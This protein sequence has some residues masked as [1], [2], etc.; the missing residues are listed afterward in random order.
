MLI[1]TT[2][3]TSSTQSATSP[4]QQAA[5]AADLTLDSAMDTSLLM[6]DQRPEEQWTAFDPEEEDGV[7]ESADK[8]VVSDVEIARAA[9]TA[10]DSL[11]SEDPKV[12]RIRV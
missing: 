11:L 4:N 10:D 8:S 5:A 6:T 12:R 7:P 9:P 2:A 1:S 3:N